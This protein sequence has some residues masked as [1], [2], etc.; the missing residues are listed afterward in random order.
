MSI[1]YG[2]NPIIEQLCADP[3]KVEQLYLLKGPLRGQLGRLA[4]LARKAGVSVSFLDKKA[5]NRMADGG[6]NQGA[7]A[8]VSEFLYCPLEKIISNLGSPGRVVVLDGVQDPQNLGSIVRT[9]VC[10]GADGI[11]IPGRNAAGMTAA[12]IK[13]SAGGATHASI[14]RVSNLSNALE[15]L[16]K[17]NLWCVAVEADGEKDIRTLD[18]SLGYTLVFGGE[19]KGIRRLVR[20]RC[21]LT[22]RIPI[23]GPLGSLNVSVAV[24]IALFSLLPEKT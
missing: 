4:R 20:E 23:S 6:A 22:A 13:A 16:K 7:V 14:A 19:G 18:P 2:I 21:D 12:A 10:A 11:V 24:G 8:R 5:L 3:A 17:A 15:K 9:S 1:I